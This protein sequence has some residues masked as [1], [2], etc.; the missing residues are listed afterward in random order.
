M[1]FTPATNTLAW[2]VPE[3]SSP[4][5]FVEALLLLEMPDGKQQY[6]VEKVQLKG[7]E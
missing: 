4:N 3:D 7:N 5:G 2:D 6:H 1:T